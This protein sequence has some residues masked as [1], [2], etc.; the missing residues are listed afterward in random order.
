[1]SIKQEWTSSIICPIFKKKYPTKVDNYRGIVLLETAY[2]VLSIAILRRIENYAND[3]VGKYQSG[4]TR[5]RSTSDHVFTIR[6]IME[7]HY[8]FD[9]D[10]HMIFIDVKQ[11]YDSID[12]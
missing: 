9:K 8:E 3:I 11:A 5:E 4:F 2:E 10:L 7:N 12:R 6:Q 1:L